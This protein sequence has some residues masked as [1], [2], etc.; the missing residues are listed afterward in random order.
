[1]NYANDILIAYNKQKIIKRGGK[2]KHTIIYYS[3]SDSDSK[4]K[5]DKKSNKLDYNVNKYIKSKNVK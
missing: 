3:D 4:L 2:Q 5:L 1:M